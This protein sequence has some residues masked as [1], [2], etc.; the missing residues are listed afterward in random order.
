MALGDGR[1]L[2]V[3][4]LD[5]HGNPVPGRGGRIGQAVEAFADHRV[6]VAFLR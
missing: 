1:V 4:F 3:R 6:H 5:T 2:L